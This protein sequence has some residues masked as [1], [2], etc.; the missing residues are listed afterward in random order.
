MTKKPRISVPS[1]PCALLRRGFVSASEANGTGKPKRGKA[2]KQSDAAPPKP[3]VDELRERVK[4]IGVKGKKRKARG[5]GRPATR[6]AE[7]KKLG[8][9]RATYYRRLEEQKAK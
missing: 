2:A 9:S 1:G 8:I 3:S 6:G 5:P 4:A 7:W